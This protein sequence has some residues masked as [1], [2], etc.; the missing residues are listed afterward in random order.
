[1]RADDVTRA[2]SL[3]ITTLTPADKHDWSRP[4]G[5][6]TWTCWET[7]EHLADCH[8]GYAA[9]LTPAHPSTTTWVKFGYRQPRPEG[10]ALT[11]YVEP[12]E[13]AGA[14]LEVLE[15]SAGLLSAVVATVPPDRM[16]F[17]SYGP[18]NAS[19]FAAMAVVEVLTH[20]HDI[21]QGLDLT[22]TPPADLCTAALRRL[23]PWA[24]TDTDPWETLL[25]ATGRADLPGQEHQTSW[26]WDGTPRDPA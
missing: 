25:W 15:S 16:S 12:E 11:L 9:Q 26:K 8:F 23:F 6:L 22:W 20:T 21:A 4:A 14:L 2:V 18:S 7:V 1:M 13:G 24:P 17:H 19:G 10:P 5:T 3:A